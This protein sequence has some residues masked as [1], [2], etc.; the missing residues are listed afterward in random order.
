MLA[1]IIRRLVYGMVTLL[2][3]SMIV[4]SLLQMTGGGP[5]DRLKLNPRMGPYIQTLTELWGLDQPAWRQYLTWLR[6]YTSIREFEFQNL[7][8]LVAVATAIGATYLIIRFVKSHRK[9][10]YLVAVWSVAIFIAVSNTTISF[11]WG[12]S[13]SGSGDVWNLIFSRAGAT[14]RLGLTA[15]FLALLIGVPL[16]IY[17]AVRQYSFFDQLGTVGAFLA[18][19]TPIFIIGIGLQ[20]VLALYL[21]K[22]TGAKLFF[23]TGMNHPNYSAMSTTGQFVNTVQHLALPAISIALISLAVYARFQR[24]SMLE[25][26]HSDYLRTAKAKGLPR[27]KV[28]VKHALRNAMIPVVTLISLDV[29][30]MIGGAIITESIF[31]W[32]GIG[33]LY[34]KAITEIDYPVVMAIVMVI[35]VGLVIMNIIADILYGVLDPRVRYD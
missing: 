35:G 26:L 8:P 4:F 30:G 14:F 32:P 5:L 13:F 6:N 22:W 21:E 24:S 10:M 18:F 19:S 12:T 9:G 1:Y 29:A 27:R 31:G 28:I 2:A 15:L 7:L 17:Q 23:V 33:R 34:I 11:E 20:I 3:L 25:V 16:G